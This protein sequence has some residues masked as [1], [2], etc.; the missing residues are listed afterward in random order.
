MIVIDPTSSTPPYEQLEQCIVDDLVSGEL[1]I[2]DRLQ[3]VRRLADELGI[4]PGT[5]AR[6]YGEL[7]ARGLVETRGRRGTFIVAAPDERFVAALHAA[8]EF[9]EQAVGELGLTPAQAARMV[10]RAAERA[11]P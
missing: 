9:L 2:G 1:Q 10:V 8:Q 5:V 3:P 11:A 7:E 4:A 6:A